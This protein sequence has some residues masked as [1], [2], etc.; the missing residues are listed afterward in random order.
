MTG[1]LDEISAA[2]GEMRADVR[3][4]RKDV[5]DL[6]GDVTENRRI[7]DRRHE[8]NKDKFDEINE[9]LIPLAKTV[10]NMKPIVDNY[11]VTRA[12]TAAVIATL[13]G[14]AA[15]VWWLISHFG[16]KAIELLFKKTGAG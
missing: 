16:A 6:K 10:A 2:I 11:Q 1:K 3:G 14:L 12:Q 15:G 8:E 7:A 4:A 13:T 9:T 5:T